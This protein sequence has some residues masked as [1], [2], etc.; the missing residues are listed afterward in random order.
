VHGLDKKVKPHHLSVARRSANSL[1]MNLRHAAALALIGWYLMVP[2]PR[3]AAC[4][5]RITNF[6]RNQQFAT[7]K[8][9]GTSESQTPDHSRSVR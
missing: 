3:L 1:S 5:W 2:P 4:V 9:R 6:P 7:H 8:S